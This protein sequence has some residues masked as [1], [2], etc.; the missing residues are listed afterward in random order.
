MQQMV[1]LPVITC[2]TSVI[3]PIHEPCTCSLE[4]VTPDLEQAGYFRHGCSMLSLECMC[5]HRLELPRDLN[6]LNQGL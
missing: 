5:S 6:T 4:D 1:L 3:H 2:E